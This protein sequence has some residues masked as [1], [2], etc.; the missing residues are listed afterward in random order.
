MNIFP[1]RLSISDVEY[2]TAMRTKPKC[3]RVTLPARNLRQEMLLLAR[4][5][6]YRLVKCREFDQP[7]YAP[8]QIRQPRT[9][10]RANG[11]LPASGIQRFLH[12]RGQ[13]EFLSPEHIQTLFKEIHW[14]AHRIHQLARRPGKTRGQIRRSLQ[15]ARSLLSQIEAAEEELYIA[16][17]R[18]IVK[19]MLHYSWMDP[20]LQEDFLQE[21]SRSLA[22]AVRRFD[23]TRGTPFIAYAQTSVQ[24][25]LRNCLRDHIRS[26]SLCLRPSADVEAVRRALKE[27]HDPKEKPPT[28]IQLAALTGLPE[29]RIRKA[30]AMI[31]TLKNKP[32]SMV[33][34]DAVT[35]ND[36]DAELYD[37]VR[38]QNVV[39]ASQS[40][41]HSE[42]WAM[43]ALLPPR[44]KEIIHLR[45]LEGHTLEET[46]RAIGL[47]R[48]RIKQIQDRALSRI[49]HMLTPPHMKSVA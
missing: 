29:D 22:H 21:G 32:A 36:N 28:D 9:Y 2:G 48:A 4:Q 47:T 30:K 26:G 24:N 38:D 6:P 44:E 7:G 43:T 15:T 16:N 12:E 17:R 25:R 45:F 42:L 3:L 20:F 18:L 39:S 40:A 11:R 46:G 41:Q 5:L 37:Y 8:V 31:A 23:F 35:G 1:G 14:C 27:W 19:C 34:L 33:S 49:R 10:H 13:V